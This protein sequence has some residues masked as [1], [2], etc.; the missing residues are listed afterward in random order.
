MRPCALLQPG[1]NPVLSDV[2]GIHGNLH[3][4]GHLLSRKGLLNAVLQEKPVLGTELIDKPEEGCTFFLRYEGIQNGLALDGPAL[5]DVISGHMVKG[6]ELPVAPDMVYGHPYCDDPQ[7]L[8][9]RT[10]VDTPV[11]SE[12]PAVT[13]KERDK[14]LAVQVLHVLVSI[15]TEVLSEGCVNAVIDQTGVL[16]HKPVPAVVVIINTAL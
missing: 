16:F 8:R 13:C 4:C 9:D 11:L 7:P 5:P 12:L 15:V 14:D 6:G 2:N 3:E 1:N 10:V